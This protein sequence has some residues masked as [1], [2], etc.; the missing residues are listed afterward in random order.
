MSARD[1]RKLLLDAEYFARELTQRLEGLQRRE[2]VS[3]KRNNWQQSAGI[4]RKV[5]GL[6]RRELAELS[7]RERAARIA[8]GRP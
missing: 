4:V 5:R 8:G 2:R 3:F 1:R 7:Q 6:L